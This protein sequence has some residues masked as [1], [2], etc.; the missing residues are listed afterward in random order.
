M[1]KQQQRNTCFKAQMSCFMSEKIHCHKRAKASANGGY[2]KQHFFRDAPSSFSCFLFINKHKKKRCCIY[3]S[4]IHENQFHKYV[5]FWRGIMKKVCVIFAMVMLLSGCAAQQ[6]FETVG[7]DYAQQV[8]AEQ[9][10]HYRLPEDAAYQTVQ[11]EYGQLYFCDGYEMTV[12]TMPA[13]DLNETLRQLTGFP[14]DDLTVIQTS[15]T[16]ASKYECVW[17][18]AGEGG[19]MVGRAVI[20]D[21]GNYHYCMTVMAM[22]EHAA[23]LRDTWKTLIDSFTLG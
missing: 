4:E 5:P 14:K 11:S 16:D 7:D 23:Q 6:T 8:I 1:H 9:T 17:T 13:G 18:A 20:L 2:T 12:Q 3:Y 22:Q 19:D 10:V 21:D 15:L